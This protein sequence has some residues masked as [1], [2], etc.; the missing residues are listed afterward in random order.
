MKP[1][2]NDLFFEHLERLLNSGS[3]VKIR[4]QGDSMYPLL[5]SEKSCVLLLPIHWG[6]KLVVGDI[7]LGYSNN[8]WVLHRVVQILARS[9][10]LRGD[11][12]VAQ[13]KVALDRVIG[14][15][16]TIYFTEKKW[17]KSDC[18][19]VKIYAVFQLRFHSVL[20]RVGRLL[21]AIEKNM[22]V[23]NK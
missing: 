22:R 2:R 5:K 18:W 21:Y 13:E 8:E 4:I 20:L 23:S 7:V 9:V 16:S 6:K 17:V 1:I 14:R 11:N 12:C 15:V 3:A 19:W 10:I